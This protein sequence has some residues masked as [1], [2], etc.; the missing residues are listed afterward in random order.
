[1]KKILFIS[2]QASYTGAPRSLLRLMRWLKEN[3]NIP[4]VTLQKED[5]PLQNQFEELGTVFN[6]QSKE[7]KSS[8]L[9]KVAKKIGISSYRHSKHLK[10]LK[11]TLIQED[12]GL[13]YVNTIANGQLLKFIVDF[14]DCPVIC[15]VRELEIWI[16]KYHKEFEL[17]KKY[18]QKYIAISEVVKSNLVKNHGLLGENIEMTY[19][20][21]PIVPCSLEKKL[22]I[23]KKFRENL[24][25]PEGAKIVC[26]SGVV[27]WNKGADLLV[28]LARSINKLNP[29]FP[30]YFL[31][32]G[33]KSD[34]PYHDQICYDTKQL[35]L[36]NNVRFL[37]L[38]SNPLDYFTS[39]DVFVLLSREEPFGMVCIEAASLGKPILCFDGAVGIKEFIED[40]CG[41]VV[42]YLDIEAMATKVLDLLTSTE[43]CQK[44]GQ[45]AQTKVRQ[46]HDIEVVAPQILKLINK[47]M[48]R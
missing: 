25:I 2:H 46:R 12:I 1:M 47:Y 42:P 39:C 29:N 21:I 38:K 23:Q 11:K 9:S 45:T 14:L 10:N 3:T 22:Q 4:L 7:L 16:R 24:S 28:Q 30:V 35:G 34:N 13:I 44:L 48:K 17:T 8:L 37:G 26:A 36:E 31:W 40:D 15:H 6:F 41:F 18:T 43:L 5:G 27:S 19:N 20:G 32:I 33:K